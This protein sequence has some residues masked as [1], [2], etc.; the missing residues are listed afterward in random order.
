MSP[1]APRP[2]LLERLLPRQ[3]LFRL[4]AINGLA[5][6]LLGILFVIGILAL[7]VAGIFT[8]LVNTGEWVIGLALLT[9]GSI[10]TFASVAMGGAIMLMPKTRE[11]ET[12]GPKGGH[13]A[14]VQ[15]PVRRR[16]Q[17]SAFPRLWTD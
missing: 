12:D 8:L 2:D 13:G 1:G 5:G 16:S 14:L 9:V 17:G 7:D 15:L 4:L 3:P 11:S 10:T 6:A